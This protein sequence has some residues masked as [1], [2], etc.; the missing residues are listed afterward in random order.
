MVEPEL[1]A[2]DPEVELAEVV[3]GLESVVLVPEVEALE[4]ELENPNP[5]SSAD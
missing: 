1:A 2:L 4:V 3:L 5:T